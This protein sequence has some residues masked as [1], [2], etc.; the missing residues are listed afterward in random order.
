MQ[1]SALSRVQG[2]LSTYLPLV[3]VSL[4]FLAGIVLASYFSLP[5]WV[6]V[7]LAVLFILLA[8]LVRIFPLSSFFFILRPFPFIL[9]FSLFLGSARYQFSVPNFDAFHIAFYNDRN[10]DLLITGYLIE[11][12][13]YRDSYTNLRLKVTAVDTGDG[14][15]PAEGLL[16][17]RVSNNQI[18]RYG[19]ILRLRG[20]LKTP[21]ENEDFSYRDYLAAQNIHSYMSSAEVTVLPGNGGNIFSAA[22]YTLKEKSLANI[23]R[24]FP[25]PE[26]SLLAGILLGVDTG[27]TK[28]LQGAFK[29]TGT[30]HII[31][32]SGFN[33]SIIAGIFFT[34]FSRFFGPRWGSA[35]AVLGIVF[36][37]LLVGGDAAVVRAAIMG[38]FALFA[39]QIGRRQFALNTLLAVAMLMCAW[40]PLYIWDVGFQL[41]FFA[42]LGLILYAEPFSNFVSNLLIRYFPVST[43]QKII[44]P[45]SDFVLLTFAAQ[46]TTI[47][48]MAYHFQ[49]ISLVSFI[50]NP[51]ILPAQPAVMILGGLAVILSLIWIPLGQLAAW[52]AYPFTLY[53]IRIVELFD[54]VPHGT[55]FLGDF[56]FGF[57]VLFYAALLSLTFG[58]S[59]LRER[60]HSLRA[61]AGTLGAGSAVVLLTIALLLIWRAASSLPDRLL[62]VTFLDVG[63]ADAVFI[64]TPSGKNIL[65]NGGPSVTILSDELGRRV[66]AFNRSLDWLIIANTDE[67][68]VASLPRALERYT[69]DNV[70]WSGNRQGSF[71]SQV[72]YEYLTLQ[73]IPVTFA[74]TNQTLDLGD[75]ATLRTLTTGA[76]GSVLLIEWQNF[77]AVLP[78]GMSFEA[79]AE[80]RDGLSVGP[81]S[82]LSLAD[83]GYAPSNPPE[84]IVNLNPEL[85][86]LNVA[87]GDE[88]GMPDDETLDAVK[89][90]ELLRTDQN[91]WIEITT[92]GEQMWVNVERNQGE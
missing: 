39:R 11:P 30:A 45:L 14:D 12:P 24:I 22:L 44:Q 53:T 16:L 88:N 66:S 90:H 63:S 6:W 70:L 9:L 84:W 92:N 4:A 43:A 65:V 28:E 68:Q 37:T 8:I 55:I 47:P 35:L 41:S 46:L 33:I 52:V 49:R 89:D 10:Y 80:L 26:S 78:I 15:L 25:D 61:K 76:R 18:Y 31:A 72:L 60:I 67:E 2:H 32:I 13:D 17:V 62:H 19:E 42:T 59:A 74:E 20:K 58:W 86:V 27:L 34:M 69:P 21:P 3:W 57:V 7:A 23:Y 29:N 91:G 71:S 82:V 64:K 87:A 36:Y 1:T 5:V 81:V 48:I 75:G 83:S 56:S 51:F 38:T 54:R 40:N 77:R 79:M 50:A 73:A 85:I